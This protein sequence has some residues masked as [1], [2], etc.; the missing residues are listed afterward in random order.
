MLD[1]P[2]RQRGLNAQ[3]RCNYIYKEKKRKEQNAK[4]KMQSKWKEKK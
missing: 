1:N 4:I 3:G 2:M